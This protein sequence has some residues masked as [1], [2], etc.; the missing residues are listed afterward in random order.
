MYTPN[1]ETKFHMKYTLHEQIFVTY[2]YNIYLSYIRQY[3]VE[4]VNIPRAQSYTTTHLLAHSTNTR[5]KCITSRNQY[6]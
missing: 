3:K 6:F 2:K 4:L 1:T 5:K